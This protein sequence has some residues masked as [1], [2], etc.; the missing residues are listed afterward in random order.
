MLNLVQK[1]G[2]INHLDGHITV[3]ATIDIDPEELLTTKHPVASAVHNG[4]LVV[5]GNF[6]DQ[7]SLKDFL[8]SEFGLFK[9]DDLN[10]GITEFVDRM[11]GIEAAF[12]PQK[13]KDSLENM[14]DFEELIPTPAKVVPFHSEQEILSEEGDIYYAGTFKSIS[15]A[16][17]CVNAVPIIYQSRFREQEM[18]F[19]RNE[20]ES[21][22]SQIEQNSTSVNLEDALSQPYLSIEERILRE[23]I[24]QMLYSKKDPKTFE[25]AIVQLRTFLGRYRFQSDVDAIID[26][27]SSTD[28]LHDRESQLLELYAHKIDAVNRE[29]F[30]AADKFSSLIQELNE[31]GNDSELKDS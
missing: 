2:D 28:T 24:P 20:I 12:D 5:Q 19:V 21:L 29:D 14:G 17:L 16:V 3:Y 10:E 15:N 6:R 31:R 26:V 8:K 27:I 22:I 9:N 7:T 4:L 1:K 13:L 30:S 18:L 11:S 23:F 25:K